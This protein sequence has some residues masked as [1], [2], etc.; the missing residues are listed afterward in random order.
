MSWA[1]QSTCHRYNHA[2]YMEVH[3]D[4]DQAPSDGPN[5]IRLA[6]LPAILAQLAEL[7]RFA[8]ANPVSI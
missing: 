5:M 7:D 2:K 6:D 1:Q 3:D 4:P 8:K